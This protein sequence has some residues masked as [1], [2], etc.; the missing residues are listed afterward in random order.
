M[1]ID[2]EYS[3]LEE[4]LL[5]DATCWGDLACGNIINCSC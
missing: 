3:V 4:N 1:T 2:V 5:V